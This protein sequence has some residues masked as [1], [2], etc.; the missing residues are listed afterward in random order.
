MPGNL[1]DA[2]EA[3]GEY[4]RYLEADDHVFG[5]EF[6]GQAYTV[7]RWVISPTRW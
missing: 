2:D 1:I 4:E 5:F 7:P 6:R 3:G